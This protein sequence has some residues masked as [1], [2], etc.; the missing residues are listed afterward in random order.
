MAADPVYL[1]THQ[2]ARM[3]GVSL[4]TVVNWTAS[5]KLEAHRTP[6]G[7]RRISRASLMAFASRFSYPLP[8]ELEVR[9]ARPRVLVVDSE[10]DF[11]EML[12]EYLQLRGR[13]DLRCAVGP[14]AIGLEIGRFRPDL[15]LVDLGL[16][17]QDPI[18]LA[19]QVAE[20]KDIGPV[21]LVGVL[22]F[23][24]HQLEQRALS[25]GYERLLHKPVSLDGVWELLQELLD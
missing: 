21:R 10:H 12:S 7:H 14:F 4:P 3:L 17:S 15:L 24:D 13:F 22:P 5:G 6:G 16:T 1:T 23:P 9:T 19:R 11:Y 25:V 2:V 8:P 20:D 18:R